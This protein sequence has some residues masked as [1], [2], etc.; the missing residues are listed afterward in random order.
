MRWGRTQYVHQCCLC[1]PSQGLLPCSPFRPFSFTPL[2]KN[3]A[4]EKTNTLLAQSPRSE[5]LTFL[6][7]RS[8]WLWEVLSGPHA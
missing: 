4:V 6:P 7:G 2:F 8:P 5:P 3:M 1:A